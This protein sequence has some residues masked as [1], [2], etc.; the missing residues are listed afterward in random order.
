MAREDPDAQSRKRVLRRSH[1]VEELVPGAPAAEGASEDEGPTQL[2]E[3]GEEAL[4]EADIKRRKVER[5]WLRH[6]RAL[7]LKEEERSRRRE[8]LTAKV[9]RRRAQAEGL[10]V[11]TMSKEEQSRYEA[12][13]AADGARGPLREAKRSRAMAALVGLE[14][15]EDAGLLGGFQTGPQGRPR[16]LAGLGSLRQ[17][18]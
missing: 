8:E 13:V 18:G 6:K 1:G 17:R 3:D 7:M 10:G 15:D 12:M 9:R 2:G 16:I 5:E 14:E 4:T 11:A